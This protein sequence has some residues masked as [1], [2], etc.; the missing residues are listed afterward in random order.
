MRSQPPPGDGVSL[1][2]ERLLA[3]RR[4]LLRDGGSPAELDWLLDL[5]GGLGWRD[6]QHLHLDPARTVRLRLTLAELEELWW[7]HR[8]QRIPLQ[9]LVGRCP[10]R[11]LVLAVAPGVLIPRQETELL[12]DLALDRAARL[13]DSPGSPARLRHWADLGTGSGAIAVALARALPTWRGAAVDCEPAALEQAGANI[14]RLTDPALVTL[15]CGR[16]WQPLRT[17]LGQLDLVVANPP[18]IPSAEV[19]RLEPLVRDREPRVAL[20]GGPDGLTAIR[21]IASGS[22]VALVPGGWLLL[23]HHHDQSAAVLELLRQAGLVDVTSA[24]DLEGRCRF[25]LARRPPS[26]GVQQDG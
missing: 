4:R 6:L 12:V 13:P 26:V 15:H 8:R 11:D 25:A 22:G 1:E 9:Y 21:D 18:Y 7:R 16:W 19:E 14:R 10:W 2:A 24:H 17:L 5:A 3:W 20:D 23:E